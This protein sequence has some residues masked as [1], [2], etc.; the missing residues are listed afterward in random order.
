[1]ANTRRPSLPN[2]MNPVKQLS[3]HDQG[4]FGIAFTLCPLLGK[5]SLEARVATLSTRRC[6]EDGPAQ[7]WRTAFGEM[8]ITVETGTTL[9]HPWV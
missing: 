5:Y 9:A 3:R 8:S 2:C 4:S 1:M 7:V 6:H